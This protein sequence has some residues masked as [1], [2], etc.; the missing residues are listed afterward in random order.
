ML[1]TN[2]PLLSIEN[3]RV[4]FELRRLGFGHAG[5]VHAVD[6]VS[7]NLT[8]GEAIAIVG[9]SGC[10]KSSLMKSIIGLLPARE[11]RILFDNVDIYQLNKQDLRTHRAR[12]GYVQQD[13]F[14]ALPPFMN[15][16]EI[17]EEPLIIEGIQTKQGRLRTHPQGA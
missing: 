16:Q 14:G 7:F 6:G 2:F 5:Y 11:G 8:Q 3:L 17:L 9:E 4:W 15:V 1:N 10:G 12:I 13:P